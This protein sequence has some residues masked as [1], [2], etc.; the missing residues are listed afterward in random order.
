[1]N[2]RYPIPLHLRLMAIPVLLVSAIGIFVI[3][4]ILRM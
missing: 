2:K 1:M 3:V 4:Q